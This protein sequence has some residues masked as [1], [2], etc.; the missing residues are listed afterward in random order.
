MYPP[1]HLGGYELTWRAAVRDLRERGHR[2]R[3]LTTK[4][5]DP[6]HESGPEDADVHRELRWYWC[7]HEFPPVGRVGRLG[8][9][10]HN[11]R[12]I[13]RHL[14][15]LRPE[16]V[17]WWAMGGMS[18]SLIERVR[19]ARIPA[20]GV[21][22]DRWMTYA[23]LVD[24]WMGPFLFRRRRGRDTLAIAIERLTGIHTSVDLAG[25]GPWLF[26]SDSVRRASLAGG[27]ELPET[28]VVHPGIDRPLFRPAPPKEWKG[29]LLC[30]GRIDRRK[31]VEL[32]IRSLPLLEGMRLDV[33]GAGD[34]DH[35]RE[36]GELADRLGV[37]GRV[38]FRRIARDDVP[39]AYAAADVL[40][41]PVQ[42]DEP[43]GLVPLEAMAIGTPVVATATGGS[44]DYLRHERNCLVFRPKDAPGALAAAVDRLQDEAALRARLREAGF[45][46]AALYDERS[47]SAAIERWL[48]RVA[49][50]HGAPSKRRESMDR[51]KDHPG[52]P[53]GSQ[54]EP[55]PR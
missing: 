39:G 40:L 9:E 20:V 41:F 44:A 12:V 3:V 24:R 15:D 21:V 19:R 51:S 46:T 5:R 28:A 2:V 26:N 37:E 4:Y 16:V 53:G 33:V 18:L 45:A 1:H 11:A 55:P 36:L 34:P 31:G 8:I 47:Y 25:A 38:T 49:S 54:A 43:F 35:L 27:W 42:W 7:D 30:L 13:D 23:H 10:H 50:S 52:L 17:N 32:A 14:A 6:D 29:R 48:Q 22:G